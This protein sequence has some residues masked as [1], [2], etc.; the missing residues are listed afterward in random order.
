MDS[1]TFLGCLYILL[2]LGAV[3]ALTTWAI[4]DAEARGKPGWAVACL[5]FFLFPV[6]PAIWV[7]LRLSK[8]PVKPKETGFDLQRYRV[9]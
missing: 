2:W 8:L 5:A 4:R 1:A 7:L 9:Q 3:Y 6:G